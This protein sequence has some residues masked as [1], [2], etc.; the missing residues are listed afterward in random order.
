[1]LRLSCAAGK[2]S[3]TAVPRNLFR[4]KMA[5]GVGCCHDGRYKSTNL[6]GKG[7]DWRPAAKIFLMGLTAVPHYK[8]LLV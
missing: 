6:V 1:M 7:K 5:A 8:R 4:M 2:Y 3:A